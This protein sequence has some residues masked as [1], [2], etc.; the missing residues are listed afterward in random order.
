MVK[1]KQISGAS[2]RIQYRDEVIGLCFDAE[3]IKRVRPGLKLIF[4]Q[5]EQ[6]ILVRLNDLKGKSKDLNHPA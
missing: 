6:P 5:G 4:A 1:K 2:R 3:S